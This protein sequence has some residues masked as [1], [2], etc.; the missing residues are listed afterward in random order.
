MAKQ[1][2]KDG[3]KEGPEGNCMFFRLSSYVPERRADIG[4]LY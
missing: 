3:G 2:A 4:D 1:S